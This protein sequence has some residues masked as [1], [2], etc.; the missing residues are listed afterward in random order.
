MIAPDVPGTR[1]D[2]RPDR[3]WGFRYMNPEG[4]METVYVY[5]YK[6]DVSQ[7]LSLFGII[8]K[9]ITDAQRVHGLMPSRVP[10]SERSA[11]SSWR[12]RWWGIRDVRYWA[13]EHFGAYAARHASIEQSHFR[14]G[15]VDTT[16]FGVRYPQSVMTELLEEWDLDLQQIEAEHHH[17]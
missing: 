3:Q 8:T 5:G 16:V 2:P 10:V 14:H 15:Q 6:S 4:N 11:P 7:L 9:R 12:P 17:P 13:L 1:Y